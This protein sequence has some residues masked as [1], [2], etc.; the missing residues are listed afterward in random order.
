MM[1]IKNHTQKLETQTLYN[2][3]DAVR[4]ATLISIPT[5]TTRYPRTTQLGLQQTH[6]SVNNFSHHFCKNVKSIKNGNFQVTNT[7]L[8][9]FF[10]STTTVKTLLE[11]GL[12]FL[13]GE[14]DIIG[15]HAFV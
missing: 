8:N 11:V 5:E 10:Y 9:K 2:L 14:G 7:T 1:G 4:I 6:I 3:A 15:V 13:N 12:S